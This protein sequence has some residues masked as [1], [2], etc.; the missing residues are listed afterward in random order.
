MTAFDWGDDS[1]H[2]HF[3][4]T[5][6]GDDR[7]RGDAVA[8]DEVRRQLLADG[9]DVGLG[10]RV[11][12]LLALAQEDRDGDGGED[13]DDDHDDEELD[14]GEALV[15]LLHRLANAS[16]HLLALS[17]ATEPPAV[18][19]SCFGRHGSL[20]DGLSTPGRRA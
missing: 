6:T 12:G 3:L 11:L 1:R 8:I 16:E 2:V 18:P 13:A 9:R 17:I 10:R 20:T 19:G 5:A 14:Q 7:D 15:L 4:A